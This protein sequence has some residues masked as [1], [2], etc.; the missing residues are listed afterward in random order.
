MRAKAPSAT[1]SRKVL[2]LE[3][4]SVRLRARPTRPT[5]PTRQAKSIT[6]DLRTDARKRRF[7]MGTEE[8]FKSF[9]SAREIAYLKRV[10]Q[11]DLEVVNFASLAPQGCYEAEYM[12][13]VRLQ[14]CA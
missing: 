14:I 12:N 6:I 4:R 11:A 1:Q 5:E 7:V 13:E 3:S 8:A 10:D 9:L 2:S